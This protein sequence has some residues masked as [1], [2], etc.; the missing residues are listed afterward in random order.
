MRTTTP[1]SFDAMVASLR[2]GSLEHDV[3]AHGTLI[4]VRRQGG[5]RV[6]TSDIAAERL[7]AKNARA[8]REATT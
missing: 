1:E 3:P 7:E 6:S 8:Q 4:R 2:E 5:L